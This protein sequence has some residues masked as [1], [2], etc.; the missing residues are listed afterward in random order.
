MKERLGHDDALDAFGGHG[1]GGT[2]GALA[3]GLFAT[4]TV[5]SGGANGLFALNPHQVWLQ[6]IGVVS[7][8]VFSG[9][10]T[11]ILIKVVD[12]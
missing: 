6:L 2:W 8:W 12:T 11:L 7:T 1:I 4:T 10:G 5:N 9:I 3:T